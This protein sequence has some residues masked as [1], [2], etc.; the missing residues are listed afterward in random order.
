MFTS[1]ENIFPQ[2]LSLAHIL[3][4]KTI[5]CLQETFY[6]QNT[7][8]IDNYY[9]RHLKQSQACHKKID[10]LMY[11]DVWSQPKMGTSL[12]KTHS[13]VSSI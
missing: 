11:Q 10:V 12:S 9:N 4:L 3:I 6:F 8:K 2:P 5:D 7:D 13:H 1:L